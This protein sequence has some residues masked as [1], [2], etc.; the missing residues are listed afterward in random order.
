M[1]DAKPIPLAGRK[2]LVDLDVAG[3]QLGWGA[4]IWFACDDADAL[5]ERLKAE[6]VGVLSPPKPGP[7]GRH[8]AFRDPFGHAVTAQTA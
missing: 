7:F 8:F 4:A 3:G 5:H 2:P 6:G 1:F